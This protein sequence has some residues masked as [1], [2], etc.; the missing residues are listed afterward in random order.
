M[1][2]NRTGKL[3]LLIIVAALV[4]MLLGT[5]V[6]VCKP[7]GASKNGHKEPAEPAVSVALGD[8]VVNLA[9]QTQVRYLKTNVVLEV[10]GHVAAKSG[11]H[12]GG[13]S[14]P[15]PKVR[16]AV[17]QV[18]SSRRMA[19]LAGSEGKE[20]LKKDIIS[21]VNKRLHEGKVVEVYFNEFAM[22]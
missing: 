5:C 21:A 1:I 11:G 2:G 20:S 17:I 12:G 18:L 10:Q 14:A 7:K 22:Q 3:P 15:D 9:D 6:F 13:D 8:F 19:D 4:L 16:D